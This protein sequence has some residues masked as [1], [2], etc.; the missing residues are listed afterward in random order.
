MR[1]A[2]A[3]HMQRLTLSLACCWPTTI[4][5]RATGPTELVARVRTDTIALFVALESPYA[6]RF[7]DNGFL[8]LPGEERAV[9]FYAWEDVPSADDFRAT[10]VVR[11]YSDVLP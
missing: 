2:R 10:L 11:T 6:G 1:A 7:D 9:P 8:M 3:F 5:A 4:A